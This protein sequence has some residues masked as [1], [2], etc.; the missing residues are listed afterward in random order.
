[1]ST[2]TVDWTALRPR[3]EPPTAEGLR[4]RKKRLMRQQLSDTATE[5]FMERGF[6]AVR[7]AE[8]AEACGVSEKTVFNYFP[9]KES[10]VL[11]LGETTMESLRTG[12][13]DPGVPPVDAVLRILSDELRAITSW[14]AAQDDPALA[15]ATV[16]RFGRLIRS[17][18]SLRA[19]Q[20]DMSDRLVGVAAE[21]LAERAGTG[22]DD[23]EPQ[24][25][26]TALLGLWPIQFQALG[27]HLDGTRTPEQLHAVVS[28]DVRRAARLLADGLATLT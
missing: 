17:T 7:V 16:L 5:M 11:D 1:M 8:I 15:G 6:E 23:P 25:A 28:A 18:P 14:L 24:I 27:R 22:P 3:D 12:L 26:A 21:I 2:R 4:E 19:Y 10:L 20:R 9:T 13:A